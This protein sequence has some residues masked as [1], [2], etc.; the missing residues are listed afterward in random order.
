[1]ADTPTFPARPVLLAQAGESTLTIDPDTN[2]GR[3]TVQSGQP[4]QLEAFELTGS[5]V[6]TDGGALLVNTEGG[7]ILRIMGLDSETV[8]FAD[9]TIDGSTLKMLA[10]V[11]NGATVTSFDG[12][13]GTIGLASSGAVDMSGTSLAGSQLEADGATVKITGSDS[14]ISLAGLNS[15]AITFADAS[16]S[17]GELQLLA[18][19]Q[20]GGPVEIIEGGPGGGIAVALVPGQTVDLAQAGISSQD[21][22]LG[23]MNKVTI[24]SGNEGFALTGLGDQS[25]QFAEGSL[26]GDELIALLAS[27]RGGSAA[28][29]LDQDLS[30][31]TAEITVMQG[32]PVDLSAYSLEDATITQDGDRLGVTLADG[33][34]IEITGLTDEPV[35]F[36]DAIMRGEPLLAL[37]GEPAAGEAG[38]EAFV[39]PSETGAIIVEVQPGETVDLTEYEVGGSAIVLDGEDIVITLAD[40]R[41]LRIVGL[42]DEPVQFADATLGGTQLA[43][44]IGDSGEGLVAPAAGPAAGPA[45]AGAAAAGTAPGAQQGGGTVVDAT[46]PGPLG[47]ALP[48]AALLDPTEL[49]FTG[50]EPEPGLGDPETDLA[51]DPDTPLGPP[52]IDPP[53]V[54]GDPV[55][56][57]FNAQLPVANQPIAPEIGYGASGV[58][59][60]DLG[61]DGPGAGTTPDAPKDSGEIGNELAGIDTVDGR[62]LDGLLLVDLPDFGQ[63]LY[64]FDNAAGLTPITA[65]MILGG[66]N[67]TV[68]PITA[69]NDFFYQ[70]YGV[71]GDGLATWQQA[72]DDGLVAS[73]TANGIGGDNDF[74]LD[75]VSSLTGPGDLDNTTRIGVV[76][77]TTFQGYVERQI[78]HLSLAGTGSEVNVSTEALRI[79]FAVDIGSMTFEAIRL[80]ADEY[81]GGDEVG[82]WT[83]YQ[84]DANGIATV[85]G[86]DTFTG[87]DPQNAS[88]TEGR[89]DVTVDA[90]V[91]FNRVE[92]TT[93]PYSNSPGV[94]EPTGAK[95]Y[96]SSDYSLSNIKIAPADGDQ[97]QYTT[98]VDV[99]AN[100]AYDPGTD[101]LAAAPATVYLDTEVV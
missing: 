12:E 7:T 31:G 97:F 14:D 74:T 40:G 94:P 42:E 55:P 98:F 25:V 100:E 41:E 24:G 51:G 95:N 22:S 10:D 44:L 49:G 29:D 45:A 66:V 82:R 85:V 6:E 67:E 17:A 18:N 58:V 5:T 43:G 64:N 52:P 70:A 62:I 90:G 1:M 69:G 33:R 65:D 36:A 27:R 60:I 63:L 13:S 99:D 37:A 68:F 11:Q 89:L 30:D 92:F 59:P 38:S 28:A 16:L 75:Q 91:A 3:V 20:G 39:L 47:D 34:V 79:D 83:A 53:P 80:F 84:V 87:T 72:I 19:I 4:V 86:T 101:V 88:L 15:Q 21:V 2:E 96:E 8:S 93:L 56:V 73:I 54:P 76:G 81:L 32:V 35:I 46:Q 23:D 77:E 71:Y 50:V 26:G 9:G 78:G 61:D 57:A 48:L